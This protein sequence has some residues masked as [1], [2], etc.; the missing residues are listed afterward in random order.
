MSQKVVL[1]TE[2]FNKLID[3]VGSKPYNEVSNIIDEIRQTAQVVQD[4]QVREV[5]EEKVDE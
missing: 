4:E 5:E 2:V 1:P 3:Y